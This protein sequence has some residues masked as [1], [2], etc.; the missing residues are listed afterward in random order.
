ML[1]DYRAW[2]GACQALVGEHGVC[3]AMRGKYMPAAEL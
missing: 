3:A 2:W 1:R